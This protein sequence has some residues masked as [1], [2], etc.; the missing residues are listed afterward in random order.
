MTSFS[1]A[2]AHFERQN[3][4]LE[5]RIHSLIIL[6]TQE[7][8]SK[9]RIIAEKEAIIA[10]KDMIVAKYKMLLTVHGAEIDETN[11]ELV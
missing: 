4:E 3:T 1:N 10:H 5:N 11:G 8:T 9:D 7:I 2:I 6:Q